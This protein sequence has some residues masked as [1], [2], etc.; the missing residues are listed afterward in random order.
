MKL[1]FKN[2]SA[3][4]IA[5]GITIFIAVYF[6]NS[7]HLNGLDSYLDEPAS[8]GAEASVSTP[9][10]T[11]VPS[12]PVSSNE[13]PQERARLKDLP[14]GK[15]QAGSREPY[16]DPDRVYTEEWAEKKI[17]EHK[18]DIAQKDLEDF[19][20][21]VEEIGNEKINEGLKEGLSA[22][23]QQELYN[24]MKS[25]LTEEEYERARALFEKYNWILSED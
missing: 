9:S 17:E 20:N 1:N 16:I 12:G 11:A 18:D 3:I 25:T 7:R 6:T 5:V 21:I 13:I 2:V 10:G 23:E 15:A 24:E 8:T 19:K 4:I 22:E 14:D